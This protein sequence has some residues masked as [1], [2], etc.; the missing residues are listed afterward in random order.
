MSICFFG[1]FSLR[2]DLPCL[3]EIEKIPVELWLAPDMLDMYKRAF[4]NISQM[5]ASKENDINRIHE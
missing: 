3:E 5:V 2:F 1:Y 4:Q